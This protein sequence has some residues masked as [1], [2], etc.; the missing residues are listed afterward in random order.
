MVLRQLVDHPGS[1]LAILYFPSF[2]QGNSDRL[3]VYVEEMGTFP[4]VQWLR[5]SLS[6]AEGAGLIS[7]WET[8]PH[9]MQGGQKLIK[10]LM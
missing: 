4:V 5:L 7:G 10:K 2:F 6:S 9:A 1:I 8:D 3:K